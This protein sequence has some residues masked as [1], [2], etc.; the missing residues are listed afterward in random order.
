MKIKFYTKLK[1][2]NLKV[3]PFII[4]PLPLTKPTIPFCI[5]FNVHIPNLYQ[6]PKIIVEFVESVPVVENLVAESVPVVENLVAESVPVVENLV[7][8]SVPV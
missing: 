1:K 8:E 6:S 7:A 2:R 5:F 3:N 4:T